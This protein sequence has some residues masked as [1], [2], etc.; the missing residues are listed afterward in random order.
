MKNTD[1]RNFLVKITGWPLTQHNYDGS[2]SDAAWEV[3]HVCTSARVSL[4]FITNKPN[5]LCHRV[6]YILSQNGK[7]ERVQGHYL[8]F[9]NLSQ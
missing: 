5:D 6:D 1:K 9:M 8:T 4:S 7:W 3:G 2:L